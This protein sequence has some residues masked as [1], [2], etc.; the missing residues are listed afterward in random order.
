MRALILWL[1]CIP[2]TAFPAFA[3]GNLEAER[4]S[5][6]GIGSFAADVT[7][8]GPRHLTEVDVLRAEVILHRVVNR[9]RDAGLEVERS[10]PD[11]RDHPANLHVHIN[12]MEVD[13]GL[14]PFSISADV[15]QNVRLVRNS[16]EMAAISWHERVLG[17][18]SSN[19]LTAIS[20]SVDALV[21][22]F[23]DD[24]RAA[25]EG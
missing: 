23:V 9:L 10:A 14:V 8:E 11:V 16:D 12:M 25:N 18:V 19:L 7:I 5:L 17:L 6:K 1:M 15:Y 3:Q 20:E 22:Q 2:F 4:T 21:D 13:R 24:Y